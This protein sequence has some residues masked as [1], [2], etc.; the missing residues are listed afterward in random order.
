MW[1]FTVPN[2]WIESLET[3]VCI[4]STYLTFSAIKIRP[5]NMYVNLTWI[6]CRFYFNF[7]TTYI[8]AGMICSHLV[9]LSLL[10]G[11]VISYGIMWPCFHGLKGN[12]YPATLSESSMKGLTGYKVGKMCTFFTL[13]IPRLLGTASYT[14]F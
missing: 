8:G 9:N 6:F 14:F 2:F 3:D 5:L 10:L 13:F 12:W 11:A 7:S 1:I 4:F